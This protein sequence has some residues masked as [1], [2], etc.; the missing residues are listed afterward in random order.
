MRP[1]VGA[2]Q[3]WGLYVRPEDRGGAA[4]HALMSTALGWG[5]QRPG[6]QPVTLHAHRHNAGA[7]RWFRQFGFE[8]FADESLRETPL[9]AMPLRPGAV[10][11]GGEDCGVQDKPAVSAASPQPRA[12]ARLA[13]RV[14]PFADRQAVP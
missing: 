9:V 4:A 6:N 13:L 11:Q 8:R 5:R 12:T 10:A 3:V 1:S 7:L 14:E 2:L